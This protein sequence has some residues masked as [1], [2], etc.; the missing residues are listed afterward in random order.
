MG[1]T[2]MW[3]RKAREALGAFWAARQAALRND[4]GMS[5]VEYALG[6]R[7]I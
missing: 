5:T 4:G 2:R 6:T 7:F 3:V 1:K